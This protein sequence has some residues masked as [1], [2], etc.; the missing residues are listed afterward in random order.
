ME[1]SPEE[2]WAILERRVHSAYGM[3]VAEYVFARKA[4][5]LP[6]HPDGTAIAVFSGEAGRQ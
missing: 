2:M 1:L 4:G 5:R 6:R 3:T